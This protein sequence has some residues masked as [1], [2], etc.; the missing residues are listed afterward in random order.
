MSLDKRLA[1][2]PPAKRALLARKLLAMESG[3]ATALVGIGCRLPGGADSP[4]ALWEFLAAGRSAVGPVPSSRWKPDPEDPPGCEFG[5][6][7]EGVDRFDADFFGIAPAEARAMD[8]QQ[9]LLLEVAWE[10]LEEAGIPPSRLAGSRTGV[11]IGIHGLSLD[12]YALRMRA[13]DCEDAHF[14]TGLSHGF[15]ANRLSFF[16]DLRGPSLGVDTS[17]SS[18]LTALHLAVRSLQS[19]E[20]ER[21]LVGAVN[22]ALTPDIGLH[23]GRLGL[24]SPTGR[25]KIFDRDADGFARAEGVIV[26][27]LERAA[28]G[29]GER[30]WLC[31]RATGAN[32]DGHSAGLAAPRGQ[33]QAALMRETLAA[34]GLAPADITCVEAHGSGS[35]VADAIELQAVASVYGAPAPV[36]CAVGAVKANLGHSEAVS[37][38]ASLA[39]VAL[40]AHHGWIPP[41]A[42]LH[43]VDP[44]LGLAS[45]RLQLEPRGRPWP[46][47]RRAAVNAYAAGGSNVHVIVEEPPAAGQDQPETPCRLLVLSARTPSARTELARRYLDLFHRRPELPFELVCHRALR[48]REHFPYRLAVVA[49]SLSEAAA[50]L[51][52]ALAGQDDP[53]VFFGTCLADDP[54]EVALV[55]SPDTAFLESLEAWGVAPEERG[56]L[57]VEVPPQDVP[58][59]LFR[60]LARLFVQGV[61]LVPPPLTGT[62]PRVPLPS[63]PFEGR[64]YWLTD[65][66]AGGPE[67]LV[68]DVLHLGPGDLD[69]H[70]PL[71]ELGLDSLKSVELV[72][73]LRGAGLA[74]DLHTLRDHPTLESLL[75]HLRGAG[76]ASSR[77]APRRPRLEQLLIVAMFLVVLAVPALGSWLRLDPA[78][79][80]LLRTAPTRFPN[81]R[82]TP[83][84]RLPRALDAWY[85]DRFGFRNSLVRAHGRLLVCHLA[86]SSSPRVVLG[87]AGWMHWR[88]AGRPS[89]ELWVQRLRENQRLLAEHGVDYMVVVT[90]LKSSIYPETLPT[91]FRAD[92]SAT[93]TIIETARRSTTVPVIDLRPALVEQ[94]SQERLYHKTGAHWNGAGAYTGYQAI[95][96]ALREK[97][98]AVGDPVPAEITSWRGPGA[99]L[100]R[101]C[102]VEDVV[103][104]ENIVAATRTSRSLAGDAWPVESGSTPP[105]VSRVLDPSLP[106]AVVIHDSMTNRMRPFLAQH[107]SQS[108]FLWA[109]PGRPWALDL[110]VVLKQRPDLVIEE[111][112]ESAAPRQLSP[113]DGDPPGP[114][115]PSSEEL[116]WTRSDTTVLGPMEL[117]PSVTSLP[118]LSV[119]EGL[120][121]VA[122]FDLE[123]SVETIWGV[124]WKPRLGRRL[125]LA[126][127]LNKGPNR[128]YLRLDPPPEGE[129]SLGLWKGQTVRVRSVEVRGCRAGSALTSES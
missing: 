72:Q 63:Y 87:R 27:V 30:P 52:R 38:L 129:L 117:R 6:F 81:L 97:N 119:P 103:S 4:Q 96:G 116:F 58:E 20:C 31:L 59:R 67:E 101:N 121:L 80:V 123:A 8:P 7:L 33:A 21:A 14:G 90:P 118:H 127:P 37:G 68:R 69:A 84:S 48:G 111:I 54:P 100:A 107:F 89:P 70:R 93:D 46:E 36:P 19:G 11:F 40:A 105:L 39:K 15:L 49:A 108:T 50:L 71:V 128:V 41:Q 60:C 74:V 91:G 92:N 83:V 43:G 65:T 53:A 86:S 44:D 120:T 114:A 112:I 3:S 2:L 9:R 23:L 75:A 66:V 104:E 12:Y 25:V 24:L 98:P 56:T 95:V 26:M 51:E 77:P 110:D 55:G 79:P 99:D 106:R 5:A 22:L 34:C 122:C 1:E 29:G 113:P 115:E 57:T 32:Q 76:E 78:A 94:K 35:K 102:A 62:V 88:S 73:R 28:S 45:T 82:T 85:R 17:C 64:R 61:A 126:A 10:A 125:T 16:F 18:G 47:P 124:H 109:G 42:N 13:G